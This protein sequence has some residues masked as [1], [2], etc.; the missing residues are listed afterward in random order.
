[1]RNKKNKSELSCFKCKEPIEDNQEYIEI[2][3]YYK[4]NKLRRKDAY[5]KPCF[6]RDWAEHTENIMVRR[7]D[8]IIKEMMGGI[9]VE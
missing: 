3:H 5:H 6:Q 8:D 7:T 1:M 2:S 4:K 9:V